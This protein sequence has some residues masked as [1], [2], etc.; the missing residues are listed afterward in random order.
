MVE[1]LVTSCQ[2]HQMWYNQHKGESFTL[3]EDCG[4][5]WLVRDAYGYKNIIK[6][7]DG[8]VIGAE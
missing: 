6:K 1:I 2:D 7:C 3:L 4:G 5:E 8:V